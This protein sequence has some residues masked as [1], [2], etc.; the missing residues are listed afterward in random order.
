MKYLSRL[1]LRQK[2]PPPPV[3]N[4][5]LGF[6]FLIKVLTAAVTHRQ[7]ERGFFFSRTVLLHFGGG[8]RCIPTHEWV[9]CTLGIIGSDSQW[10]TCR[11]RKKSNRNTRSRLSRTRLMRGTQFWNCYIRLTRLC[12]SHARFAKFP[13]R[14]KGSMEKKARPFCYN[15]QSELFSLPLAPPCAPTAHLSPSLAFVHIAKVPLLQGWL[16]RRCRLLLDTK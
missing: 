10:H 13:S 14:Q 12:T 1:T 4:H 11:Q 16:R 3:W 6:K 2:L 8:W 9:K 5:A 15:W 7:G